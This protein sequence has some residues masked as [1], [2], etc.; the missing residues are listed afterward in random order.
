MRQGKAPFF[1]IFKGKDIFWIEI[2]V[3]TV[4]IAQITR[5]LLVSDHLIG[6]FYLYTAVIR[7][8]HQPDF[9][10]SDPLKCLA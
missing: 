8:H 10:V 7:G 3:F 1:W 5:G 4:F 2:Q 9:S 6:R